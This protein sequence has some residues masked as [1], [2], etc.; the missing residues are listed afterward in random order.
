MNKYEWWDNKLELVT[1]L[2]ILKLWNK[3]IDVDVILL[4]QMRVETNVFCLK[5]I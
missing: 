3:L 1:I 5:I 4:Q 2:N